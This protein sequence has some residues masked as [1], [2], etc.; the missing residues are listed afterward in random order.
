MKWLKKVVLDIIITVIIL[1][2]LLIKTQYLKIF[3]FIYTPL[4]L[5]GRILAFTGLSVQKKAGS[6]APNWFLHL[7]YA[8]NVSVLALNGWWV[9][10]TLWLVIWILAFI[11]I[12]RPKKSKGKRIKRL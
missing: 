4:M 11:Y 2:T 12:T 9:L 8:I 5:I 10:A 3:L 6:N 7:L 1:S